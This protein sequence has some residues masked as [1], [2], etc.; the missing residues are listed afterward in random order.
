MKKLIISDFVLASFLKM[1]EE[2]FLVNAD[3]EISPEGNF[4]K[5]SNIAIK[6]VVGDKKNCWQPLDTEYLTTIV[7][8]QILAEMKLPYLREAV[9]AKTVL[10]RRE[11]L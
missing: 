3:I 10:A 6:P 7:D 2:E 4:V 11:A 9:R 1:E 8:K 5:S